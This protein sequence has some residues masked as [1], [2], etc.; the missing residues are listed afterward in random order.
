MAEELDIPTDDQSNDPLGIL[1]PTKKTV[2]N[3]DP[4]GILKKKVDGNVSNSG[5]SNGSQSKSQSIFDSGTNLASG[6]IFKQ[7]GNEIPQPLQDRHDEL[8]SAI[9]RVNTPAKTPLQKFDQMAT[10]VLQFQNDVVRSMNPNKVA[11]LS[12]DANGHWGNIVQNVAAN[13]E[14]AGTK[15][16]SGT[17]NLARDAADYLQNPAKVFMPS[18]G[19]LYDTNGELSQEGKEA[20]I[21]KD[22]LGKLIIGLNGNTKRMNAVLANNQLPN[23]FLGNTVNAIS[24]IAPDIAAATLAP[25]TKVAEGASLLS[26]AGG[27]L[28]NKF[29]NYLIGKGIV[30][31]YGEAKDQ[32]ESQGQALGQAIKGGAQGAKTGIELAILGAGSGLATKGI[33]A[34]AAE[35]GLIGAKGVATRQLVNLG[36]D[37]VAYSLIQPTINAAEEGRFPTLKEIADGAGI[38]AAFRIKGGAEELSKHS[39]L[40]KAIQETQNQRQGAAIANFVDADHEAIKQVYDSPETAQELNLKALEAAKKAKEETDLSKKQAYVAQAITFTK[41]SNVKSVA[42]MVLNN[43]QGLEDFKNSPDIPDKVKQEFLQKAQ[44]VSDLLKPKAEDLQSTTV[45]KPEEN[46]PAETTTIAP[47]EYTPE[48]KKSGVAIVLPKRGEQISENETTTDKIQHPAKAEGGTNEEINSNIKP[49]ENGNQEANAQAE[50][51]QNVL[52]EAQTEGTGGNPSTEPPVTEFKKQQK[53]NDLIDKYNNKKLTA[54][55]EN[56]AKNKARELGLDYDKTRQKIVNADGKP[57]QKRELVTNKTPV[58]NFDR[59]KYSQETNDAIDVV[60]DNPHAFTGLEVLGTDGKRLSAAQREAAVESIKSGKPTHAAKALFDFIEKAKEKGGVEI[61]DVTTGQRALI[62]IDEYFEQFKKP[63]EPLS[64]EELNTEL[65]N[66]AMAQA[67]DNIINEQHEN[68]DAEVSGT[69]EGKTNES[70][71]TNGSPKE[72]QGN[73]SKEPPTDNGTEANQD[74]GGGSRVVGVSHNSLVD[75]AKRIGL[76]EPE[77]GARL[78]PEQF[79]E[80]GRRLYN[81]GADIE[82]LEKDF[83]SGKQPTSDDISV[84]RAHLEH[85]TKVANAMGEKWGYGS[86]Q[87]KE[88]KSEIERFNKD[89]VKP[90]GTAASDPFTALQ[91]ARDLD[92][93]SFISIQ[94]KVEEQTGKPTTPSQEAKIKKITE[95]SKKVKAEADAAEKKLIEA[96]DETIGRKEPKKKTYTEKAKKIADNFRKLKNKPFTF[97]DE[98]GNDIPIQIQGLAWNDI[99]EIGAKA[100]EKTGEIADGIEAVLDKIKDLEWYGKLSDKDKDRFKDELASHYQKQ[101]EN[102]PEAK[103]IKRLE[104]QLDDLRQRKI[105]SKAKTTVEDSPRVKQLKDEIFEEKQKLGLISSKMKTVPDQKVE[106]QETPETKNVR[107]LE[108]ELEDLRNGIA[109]QT[110]PSRELTER[111]KQLQEQIKDEKEK[112]GL[113]KSKENKPLTEQE[114]AEKKEHEREELANKFIDKTDNKF[115]PDESKAIWEYAKSEYLDH[116]TGYRGMLSLVAE[117]LGLTMRQVSEAITSPKIKPI[118]DAMYKKQAEMRGVQVQVKDFVETQNRN[119][120]MKFLKGISDFFRSVAVFGHG[121]IFVGT[122]AGMTLFDLPRAKHTLKAMANGIKFAYGNE[123]TYERQMDILRNRKNF[124]LAQKAGLQNDPNESK[125]DDYQNSSKSLGKWIGK[126]GL[127]GV[128]GFNAIKVLRQDLFDAHFDKLNEAQ[129]KDPKV[130]ESIAQLV[131]NATGA[132]NTTLPKWT[133]EVAFAANMEAAR[134]EKLTKNPATATAT[135]LKALITPDKASEADRVFAK[136]WASRVGWEIATYAGVL[137]ANAAIQ[138]LV[139]NQNPVNLTRP[140]DPDFLKFKVG[141]TDINPT[142]GMLGSIQFV[143]G[144]AN[145][146]TEDQKKLKGDDRFKVLGKNAI[147]YVRGKL[148]PGWGTL[149]DVASHT[150]FSGNVLPFYSDKPK[151]GKRQLTYGEYSWSKAPIPVAEAAKRVYEGMIENG[152][153]KPQAENWWAGALAMAEAASTGFRISES[154]PQKGVQLSEEDKK[155]PAFKFFLDKGLQLPHTSLSS[156]EITDQKNLTKKKISDFSKEVQEKYETEHRNELR[157]ELSNV[158]S[159]GVVYVRTYK[160]AQNNSIKDVSLT[161]KHLAERTSVKNLSEDELTQVL[162]LSQTEATKRAKKK[163]FKK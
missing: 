91:G 127:T 3:T 86:K 64:I 11:E 150:D 31:G 132:T 157:K 119:W 152:M 147:G 42:D 12:H 13:L 71:D 158:L 61:E 14:K 62:P 121:H 88:A 146:V 110:S 142:S 7:I 84:A 87:Y 122:H 74:E 126:M 56:E 161:P 2:D 145:V 117:D 46:V 45:I 68:N 63:I 131:N 135:A 65:Q 34:K 82:Q 162:R 28:F 72:T 151:A 1:T 9:K 154:H 60:V 155:A 137:G 89:I 29:T 114:I 148:S 99:V 96:T 47:K 105:E 38:A 20:T 67:F 19:G 30:T 8:H 113:G 108:K 17:A 54:A 125:M 90:M 32:G 66:D 39:T 83:L 111:E 57:I 93:D 128:K 37:L 156:E 136:V 112:L 129:K 53:V 27:L 143:N 107:R 22:P 100:I 153:S 103:K 35:K 124:T 69:T 78:T 94:Q 95:H 92:T 23:T 59:K 43:P 49:T 25:E 18:T 79:A 33:M 40:N 159:K 138:S 149:A 24:E 144:I 26:K 15:I 141:N 70:A 48:T 116:G 44:E 21:E 134:W 104:K 120:A 133:Q 163:I 85:L 109:K 77:R 76:K 36:T 6:N 75:L 4:L 139:N 101:L 51:R 50:G 55:E 16:V 41:A 130:I 118:S 140:N 10:P 5:T 80:R 160:D 81:A 102:T 98:N 123:A 52:N 106:V 58:E 115:T 73:G 97:K